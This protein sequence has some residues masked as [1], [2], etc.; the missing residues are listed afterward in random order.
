MSKG[1]SALWSRIANVRPSYRRTCVFVRK[2]RC[3]MSWLCPCPMECIVRATRAQRR[4]KKKER[5][6][7]EV[8]GEEVKRGSDEGRPMCCAGE[9]V[10]GVALDKEGGKVCGAGDGV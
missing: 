2:Y 7:R 6:K 8:R 5:E 1:M 9:G 3:V 10:I 4:R